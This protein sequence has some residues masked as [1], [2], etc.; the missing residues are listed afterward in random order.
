MLERDNA[1]WSYLVYGPSSVDFCLGDFWNLNA[2]CLS[3][4]FIV[5]QSSDA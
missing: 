4:S 3:C 5:S 1:L 2:Q